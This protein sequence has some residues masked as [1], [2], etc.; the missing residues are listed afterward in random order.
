MTSLAK[1]LKILDLFDEERTGIELGEAVAATGAS[2]ATVYR[3]LKTLSA[4]GMIAP[5]SGGTFVLGSRIIELERMMRRTDPLATAARP[6]MQKVSA[7]LGLNMM[8]CSYYGDNVM[9]AEIVWPDRAVAQ[10]Y[11]R[12]RKMPMF[13][14][15]MAKLILANLTP[16]QLRNMMLWHGQEIRAADLG[17]NWEEFRQQM[18]RI[19]KEGSC[20]TRGEVVDGLVG[21]GAPVFDPDG[22]ILGSIVFAVPTRKVAKLGESELRREIVEVA[23]AINA[24]IAHREPGERR[25]T[26][27]SARPRRAMTA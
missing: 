23:A 12:G 10:S 22:R 21:I 17:D 19:R 24:R 6:I 8:L 27:R 20:V 4:A 26:A 14:G 3:Y 13:R 16:Y 5:A 11:E 25:I 2:R 1:M 18:A 7:R 15:A 9:C